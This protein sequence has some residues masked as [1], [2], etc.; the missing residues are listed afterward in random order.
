MTLNA[1]W[2]ETVFYQVYLPSFKDGNGD[3]LGD[4]YGL[5]DKLDYLQSLGVKGI[6]VT[7]F[8]PSPLVD[9]GYDVS[10]YCAVASC[11]GTLDIF[12]Q[13][14]REAHQRGI[15][16]VI[17]VVLNHVSSE[18]PW[19][20]DALNNPQ[21][22]YRDFFIFSRQPNNWHSFFGGSA[23]T[24]EADGEHYYYHKFAPQQVDLNW[25]N[26]AV[27]T[28]AK[29]VLDF[30]LEQGV[31]GFRFDVINFFTCAPMPGQDNPTGE[32]GEQQHIFDINQP[33]LEQKLSELLAHVR[34]HGEIFIIGE[35]G[36]QHLEELTR[37]QTPSLCDVVF[38]FNLGSLPSFDLEAIFTQLVQMDKL[39]SAEPTLFFSSHDMPRMMSR[40]AGGDRARARALACLQL[41]GRGVPFI[42][43]GEEIGMTDYIAESQKD[44]HDIQGINHY[45]LKLAECGDEVHAFEYALTKSR[46]NARSPLQWSD[47]SY[48]GFSTVTPWM[49]VNSNYPQTNIAAAQADLDSLW[50]AYQT[51][52]SLRNS[53]PVFQYGAYE[54]LNLEDDVLIFCRRHQGF[55]ATVIIN[56]GNNVQERALPEG[57]LIYD[58]RQQNTYLPNDITIC[59]EEVHD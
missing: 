42:Y 17:D 41:T 38:N 28:E 7:P 13:F 16:V 59:L 8:Y 45:H 2:R 44:I 32:D 33:G 47:A 36:S 22:R 35:V 54:S 24:A 9:N 5:I 39:Q 3:G 29:A 20:Q 31:D 23:W 50:Y 53:Y 56:F 43:A 26:P 19:F 1:W 12:G 55:R 18:H 21:S 57:K 4:F 10:D 25:A 27:M 14:I 40:L 52:I 15:K 58:T 51:L 11:F 34:R 30:W 49:P 46:D 48:A 37:F 6:W